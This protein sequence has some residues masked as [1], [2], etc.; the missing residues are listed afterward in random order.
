MH[1]ITMKKKNEYTLLVCQVFTCACTFPGKMVI[2][3]KLKM[4]DKVNK[5]R[6]VN[7]SRV[8]GRL[9]SAKKKISGYSRWPY[10]LSLD[11]CQV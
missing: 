3:I 1:F 11:S 2:K 10:G 4:L 9:A 8:V 5:I 7:K 6:L